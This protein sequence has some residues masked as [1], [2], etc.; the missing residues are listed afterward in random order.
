MLICRYTNVLEIYAKIEE[1]GVVVGG[2]IVVVEEVRRGNLIA[3]FSINLIVFSTATELEAHV[4]TLGTVIGCLFVTILDFPLRTDGIGEVRSY[5]RKDGN[6]LVGLEAVLDNQGNFEVVMSNL[7][8][9]FLGTTLGIVKTRL[10]K[11]RSR[12]GETESDD[13]GKRPTE[14]SPLSEAMVPPKRTP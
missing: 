14:T 12:A 2:V 10:E 11:Y 1:E 3:D 5:E 7:D 8:I 6:M 13:T 9:S 4:V